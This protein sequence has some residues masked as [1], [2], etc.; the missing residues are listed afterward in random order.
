[1]VGV[2]DHWTLRCRS[3]WPGRDDIPVAVDEIRSL[4]SA[5]RSGGRPIASACTGDAVCGRCTVRILEGADR[6]TAMDD[7]ER[8]VLG[9]QG[10][11]PG[12]RLAC[13]TWATGDGVVVGTDYW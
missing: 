5:L 8:R 2:T 13:R 6:V 11:S 10:A 7:E 3:Q 12:E 9:A 4:Y 1:M